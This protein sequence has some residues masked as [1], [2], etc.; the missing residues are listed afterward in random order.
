M[1]FSL[2]TLW[3][4][5]PRHLWWYELNLLLWLKLSVASVVKWVR[6]RLMV[7]CS[8]H[9][10]V[11]V[12]WSTF[13]LNVWSNASSL[14]TLPTVRFAC[15]SS[16][17]LR[18]AFTDRLLASFSKRIQTSGLSSS[19]PSWWLL[20]F[21]SR[22]F[23]GS[24]KALMTAVSGYS[25]LFRLSFSSFTPTTCSTSTVNG[26]KRTCECRWSIN[27][28]RKVLQ[29]LWTVLFYCIL[30][31]ICTASSPLVCLIYWDRISGK[32]QAM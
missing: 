22:S 30:T 20:S 2:L 13:T 26:L 29:T 12:R 21:R 27:A 28:H 25:L 17:R 24:L 19:F 1:Y 3:L 11:Q 6:T 9:A 31:N 23:V 8:L 32:P 4:P 14:V 5:Q 7:H 10:S 15:P 18:Y 16:A